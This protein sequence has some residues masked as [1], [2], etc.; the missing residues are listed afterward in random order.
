MSDLRLADVSPQPPAWPP[1]AGGDRGRAGTTRAVSGVRQIRSGAIRDRG[2][3]VTRD[4]GVSTPRRRLDD[5]PPAR[6][7]PIRL[8]HRRS[9]HPPSSVGNDLT[10]KPRTT[11]ALSPCPASPSLKRQ[12]RQ[13]GVGFPVGVRSPCPQAR[14]NT[15]VGA[16]GGCVANHHHAAVRRSVGSRASCH[17]RYGSDQGDDKIA[18]NTTDL[19]LMTATM[20]QRPPPA[21]RGAAPEAKVRNLCRKS[22]PLRPL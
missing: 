6:L 9:G 18:F 4:P 21:Q 7:L 3:L 1:S 15:G 20:P 14:S 10:G 13:D 17:G 5:G 8:R 11:T 19:L 2:Q 22:A 12:P 16:D